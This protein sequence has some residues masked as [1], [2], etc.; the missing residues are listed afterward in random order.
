MITGDQMTTARVRSLKELRVRDTLESR[1]GFA[2]TVSGWLYTEM[3]V[4]NG[5]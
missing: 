4:A 1:M 2:D 5:I 3:A